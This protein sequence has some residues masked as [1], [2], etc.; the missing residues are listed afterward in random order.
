MA[1]PKKSTKMPRMKELQDLLAE[2]DAEG[3]LNQINGGEPVDLDDLFEDSYFHAILHN[4]VKESAIQVSSIHTETTSKDKDDTKDSTPQQSD[5]DDTTSHP[6][7]V[8]TLPRE[9]SW[10]DDHESLGHQMLVRP[11][12]AAVLTALLSPPA[13]PASNS[14]GSPVILIANG[15]PGIGKSCLAYYLVF[16]LFEAGHDVVIS[17]PMFTNA[18]IQKRYY[19][20]YSPHLS[21]HATI[22]EAI[23]SASTPAPASNTDATTSSSSSSSSASTSNSTLSKPLWWICDDGFLPI[24][25]ARCNV[26]V[27]TTATSSSSSSSSSSSGPSQ[28]DLAIE[29]IRKRKLG[30]P[31]V[32]QIPKWSLLEVKAGLLATLSE[33]PASIPTISPEQDAVLASLFQ[34]FKGNPRKIFKWIKSNWVTPASPSHLSPSTTPLGQLKSKKSKK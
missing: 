31:T 30:Q 7:N 17:D 25:N 13:V 6:F 21:R 4:S 29:T 11:G 15:L 22:Y 19:S 20:C 1:P 10:G 9:C 2:L 33:S 16:K 28:K 26:L 3:T 27:N 8:L 32:F 18:F 24:K 34:K 12:Y 14:E 23:S 5:S